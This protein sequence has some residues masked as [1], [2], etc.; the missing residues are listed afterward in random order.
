MATIDPYLFFD[1][2]CA[3]AM[4]F[5]EKTLGGKLVALMTHG[6]SPM[7]EQCGGPEMKDRIMHACLALDGRALMASDAMPDDSYQGMQNVSVALTYP[8]A[9]EAQKVFGLLAEGGQVQ[10]PIDKT[11]FAEA[12][13]MVRDRFGTSWFV[14][15]GKQPVPA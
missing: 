15:G 1:G 11:F 3:D 4:R 10:M 2:N 7:A 8:A 13:G 12:F 9:D 5:Y 14:S 6:E